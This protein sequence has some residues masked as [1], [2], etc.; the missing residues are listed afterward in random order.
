MMFHFRGQA[1]AR[2]GIVIAP[3]SVFWSL[4]TVLL[5]WFSP[6]DVFH[7]L[8]GGVCKRMLLLVVQRL[9]PAALVEID[10][11]LHHLTLLVGETRPPSLLD[12]KNMYFQEIARYYFLNSVWYTLSFVFPFCA[13]CH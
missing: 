8:D 10:S 5:P 7:T 13:W 11:R 1:E 4:Y 2:L 6:Q 12:V 3:L 9:K